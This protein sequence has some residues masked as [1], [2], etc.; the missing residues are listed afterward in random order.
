[1][2]RHQSPYGQT[3]LFTVEEYYSSSD[4]EIKIIEERYA[5]HQSNLVY[6]N[7]GYTAKDES[8]LDIKNED[9]FLDDYDE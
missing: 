8:F 9:L 5:G 3:I 4:N 2:I 7:S 1:M 6:A